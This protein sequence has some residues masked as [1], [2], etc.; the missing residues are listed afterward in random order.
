[1]A[2]GRKLLFKPGDTVFVRWRGAEEFEIIEE[3]VHESFFPHYKCKS[4][5]GRRY[6]YWV[7]PQIHMSRAPIELLIKEHNHKQLS[8]V[9]F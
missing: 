3:I 2:R 1:M 7:I 9:Q 5:G 6:D 4:W 8:L